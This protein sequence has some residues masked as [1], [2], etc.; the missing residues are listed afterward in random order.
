MVKLEVDNFFKS[1]DRGYSNTYRSDFGQV[2]QEVCRKHTEEKVKEVLND[3]DFQTGY[4][5]NQQVVS[6]AIKRKIIEHTPEIF[7]TAI[8]NMVAQ[9]VNNL[10]YR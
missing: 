3:P 6:E 2:V 1:S 9:A 4:N 7:A 10:K 8:E 5:G